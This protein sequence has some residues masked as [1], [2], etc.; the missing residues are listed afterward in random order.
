MMLGEGLQW[1][2]REENVL[3]E[4]VSMQLSRLTSEPQCEN[5]CSS[6][7]SQVVVK[8][9]KISSFSEDPTQKGEVSFQQWVFEA[10]SVM[11][12]HTKVI[13]WEGMVSSLLRAMAN[14]VQYLGLQA[15]V[16]EIIN[17]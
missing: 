17:K 16:S 6:V 12:S 1:V 13:L 7:T 15:L 11:Q 8:M 4:G 3:A 5:S 2:G 10:K 9:P 14:L